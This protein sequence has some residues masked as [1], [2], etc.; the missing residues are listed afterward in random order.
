MYVG[1]SMDIAGVA[2]FAA[3][4]SIAHWSLALSISCKFVRHAFARERSRAGTK[5]CTAI[6]ISKPIISTTI[7]ISTNVKPAVFIVL[8]R[9]MA[10]TDTSRHK[11]Q[12]ATVSPPRSA[13]SYVASYWSVWDIDGLAVLAPMLHAGRVAMSLMVYVPLSG[14]VG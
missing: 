9:R 11:T 12:A 8:Q 2:L 6:D 5:V 1:E 4:V 3:L 10:F 13:S 7:I 14:Q